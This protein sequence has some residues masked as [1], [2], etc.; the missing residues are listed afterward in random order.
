MK[1]EHPHPATPALRA[2]VTPVQPLRGFRS[3][4]SLPPWGCPAEA[5]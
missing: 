1:L 2:E 3:V 5:A 4:D